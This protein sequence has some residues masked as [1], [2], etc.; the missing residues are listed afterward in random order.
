MRLRKRKTARTP[1]TP[2]T[3]PTRLQEAGAV[4]VVARR[5]HDSG[6]RLCEVGDYIEIPGNGWG[7]VRH[8]NDRN[9]GMSVDLFR[10]RAWI[11]RHYSAEWEMIQQ[12]ERV[13]ERHLAKG[14]LRPGPPALEKLDADVPG[15]ELR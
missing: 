9:G 4:I 3:L 7:V 11:R 1:R 14:G 15:Y 6:G 13:A 2:R 5:N 12:F 8:I 10:G